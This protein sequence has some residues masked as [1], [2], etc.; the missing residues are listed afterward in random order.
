MK[1]I[2]DFFGAFSLV[3]ALAAGTVSP[4]SAAGEGAEIV[5]Q[6]WSFSGLF[7]G[8]DRAQLQRGL[9]VYQEVCAACHGLRLV[10]YRNLMDIG[11]S[12]DQVKE[13]AASVEVEDGPDE[14]GEMFE[15]PG[16]P[17]DRFV[18]P[19]PNDNAARVANN[20]ALPPD[21]SLIVKARLGGADYIYGLLTGFEEPPADMEMPDGMSYN[22]AYSGNMIAMAQPL[23]EDGVE[24]ADGTKATTAQQAR[25]VTAFLAWTSEPELEERKRMGI[26]VVLFLLLLTGLLYVVK[27]RVWSNLHQ[28]RP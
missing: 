9:Q 19:F 27:R 20:G 16:K 7:G 4:A 26:K 22:R 1:Q 14:E 12:E 28:T 5:R 3:A 2:R 15:R 8:F 6:H 13:I 21:L 10:A 24:Y 25:D 18:S 23:F 11:L 17:S